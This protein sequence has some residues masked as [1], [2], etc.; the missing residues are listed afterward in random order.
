M[1][2]EQLLRRGIVE[3]RRTPGL[4]KMLSLCRTVR[5]VRMC[6][7]GFQ[8]SLSQT[9]RARQRIAAHLLV[10]GSNGCGYEYTR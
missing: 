2:V 4:R 6:D 9:F 3:R 8:P 7:P 5:F 1:P 10:F